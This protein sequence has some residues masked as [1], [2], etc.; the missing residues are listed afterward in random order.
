MRANLVAV[1]DSGLHDLPP[2]W[3][4]KPVAWRGWERPEAL[5][6][7]PPR[8][9]PCESCGS[10][11]DQTMNVGLVGDDPAM[12]PEDVERDDQLV[13]AG[14]KP[15]RSRKSWLKLTAFRCVDCGAD[16]VLDDDDEVWTLDLSDYGD[17][18]ST[19]GTH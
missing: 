4:G 10:L 1:P 3:D 16:S 18:G 19:E 8:K 15:P 12:T 7:C 6:I 14:Y 2:R 13:R 9:D 5:F 17:A 11:A